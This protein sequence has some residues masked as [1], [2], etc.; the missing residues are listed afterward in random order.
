MTGRMN[1]N[2]RDAIVAAG[3]TIT[4]VTALVVTGEPMVLWLMALLVLWLWRS[5]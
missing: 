2:E 3:T 5:A 1:H 4:V